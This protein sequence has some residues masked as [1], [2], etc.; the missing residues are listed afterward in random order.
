MG[1]LDVGEQ[2]GSLADQVEPSPEQIPGRSHLRRV[3][4]RL[5]KHSSPHEG[6]DLVGVDAVVLGLAAVDGLHV[7]RVAEDEGDALLGAEVGQP[8]PGEGALDRDDEVLAEGGD[9]GEEGLWLRADVSVQEH[10]ALLV[11]NADVHRLRVQID[12]AVVL[13]R[14]G[15]ESH[16][17]SS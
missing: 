16:W 13:V 17:V 14:I 10:L 7:E 9:C 8:V 2:L 6:R 1:V 11:D 15:V 3:D 5:G 12:P 4:V